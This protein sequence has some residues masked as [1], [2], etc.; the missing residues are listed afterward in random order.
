MPP[1]TP[2]LVRHGSDSYESHFDFAALFEF[3]TVINSSVEPQF[4]HSHILL[5]IMGKILA[6]R[7]MVLLLNPGSRKEYTVEMIK[8]FPAD[9]NG[10]RHHDRQDAPFAD[11]RGCAQAIPHLLGGD[12]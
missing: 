6:T 8:G 10:K 3:S 4:I 7:G 9:L 11:V 2:R 5:T 1:K 12:N